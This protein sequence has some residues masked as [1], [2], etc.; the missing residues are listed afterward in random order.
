VFAGCSDYCVDR[1]ASGCCDLVVSLVSIDGFPFAV[2]ASGGT[3]ERARA[4]AARAVSALDWHAEQLGWRPQLRL[5]VA[6]GNDGPTSPPCRSTACPD[7]GRP[8]TIVAAGEAPLFAQVSAH[9][10]AHVPPA[11]ADTLRDTYGDPPLLVG[12]FDQF[13]PH[14]LVHL[15]CE[16]VPV[17]PAPLWIVELF[18]NLGMVGYLAECEPDA[19]QLLRAAADASAHIPLSEHPIHALDDMER[20]FD[21]G[22]LA[23]GWYILRLTSLADRLWHDAGGEFYRALY[24]RLR[25]VHEP[26]VGSDLA[27]LDPAVRPA[28]AAWPSV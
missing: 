18:C 22:Q 11:P 16:Q 25:Q 26:V 14:E 19:L 1:R 8:H 21:A 20:S 23:F 27:A 17:A 5:T 2:S 6:D 15:F 13:L 9:L 3:E 24:D 7:L 28:L 12:F 10:L 4:L